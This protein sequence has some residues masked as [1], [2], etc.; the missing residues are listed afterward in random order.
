MRWTGSELRAAATCITD[1]LLRHG[2]KRQSG[3]LVVPCIAIA[4]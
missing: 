2:M 1:G 4:G 3:L